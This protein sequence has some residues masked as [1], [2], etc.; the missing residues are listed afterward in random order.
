[1]RDR[2]IQVTV[3]DK[4][5]Y[6]GDDWPS[7]NGYEFIKWFTDKLESIPEEFKKD[8]VFDLDATD[9][10]GSP[11]VTLE[12]YYNRPETQEEISD[13]QARYKN[14]KV[15]QKNNDIAEFE[16]LKKKLNL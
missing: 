5:Q 14:T 9:S 12:L 8:A 7:S 13:R 10:Y 15:I 16:R 1:M 4:E 11:Y 3:F 2:K 6:S